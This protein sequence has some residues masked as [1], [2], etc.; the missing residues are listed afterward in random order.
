[1]TSSEMIRCI[2]LVR[3]DVLKEGNASIVRVTRIDEL[4]TLAEISS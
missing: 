2:D 4:A 1:M 3:T